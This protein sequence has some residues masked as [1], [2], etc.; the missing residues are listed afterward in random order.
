MKSNRLNKGLISASQVI[1]KVK[2]QAKH[3]AYKVRFIEAARGMNFWEKLELHLK[4][5]F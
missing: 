3:D 5:G 4:I 1:A 2:E